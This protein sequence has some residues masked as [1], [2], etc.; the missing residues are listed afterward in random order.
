MERSIMTTTDRITLYYAPQTRAFSTR[1]ILTELGAPFDLHILN[2]KAGE[3]RQPPFLAINPLGKV[4]TIR[5]G[6]AVITEQVA[7]ALYLGDLFAEKGMAPA[8]T[9][10]DRGPYLRWMA[11]YAA[12]FE[13]ALMDRWR[14]VEIGDPTQSV[15]SSYDEMLAVLEAQLAKGPYLLGDRLTVGD[16]LWGAALDWTTMFGLVPKTPVIAAY[17]ERITGR[18]IYKS[19]KSEDNALAA[20]HEAI[21]AAKKV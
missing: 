4:P 16:L 12:C 5:H 7:I 15:Y 21:V 14:Q 11:F 13:P 19:L 9:D 8:L 2:M 17:V 20:E 6:D 10:P 18:P 3:Q 1:L